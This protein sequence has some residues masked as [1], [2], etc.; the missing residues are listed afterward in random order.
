MDFTNIGSRIA[1]NPLIV[2]FVEKLL[3][4]GLLI[5]LGVFLLVWIYHAIVWM[6]IA[7]KRKHKYPWLAWIPFANISL[8]LELG[9]FHWA[10]VFL[11]L[12]PIAGWIALLVLITI[13]VWNVFEKAK[14]PG[15]LAL[16]YILT[17]IPFV[18]VGAGIAYLIIIGFVAWKKI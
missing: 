14:Y 18:A 15:W 1:E 12:V 9:G 11:I 6:K 17:M 10:W 4:M 13:A 5:L 7:E 16:G 8:M 3:I 2:G